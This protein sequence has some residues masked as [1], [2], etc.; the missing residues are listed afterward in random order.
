MKFILYA[1]LFLGF[2][3]DCFAQQKQVQGLVL[4]QESKLRLAKV[5][6]QNLRSGDALYNTTKGEFST[7]ASKGDTLVARLNGYKQD[8]II[9]NG[10][11]AVY[12][13]LKSI[14][15]RLRDVQ[16]Q[17]KRMTPK[18]RYE[19]S[20][21]DNRY[22][23]LRGSTDDIINLSNNGA[24]L[25]IDAIY[26]LFS[27]QGKN[28]RY[29]QKILKNDYRQQLIDY[30]FSPR[31]VT[32]V[33]NINGAEREDFMLQY[34]PTYQFVMDSNDYTFN[35]FIKNAY[36]SYRINPGALRLP[37]LPSLNPQK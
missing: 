13:Q 8:T 5:Y 12:F 11:A 32:Q 27:R 30:R 23:I 22:A 18:E 20:L 14:G 28:A 7:F 19:E 4:D 16:I 31:L 17:Q 34:R 2:V 15:I 24:G 10:Q 1:F 26:N 21:K 36:K 35:L 3:A 9:Y 29:L 37:D 25:G 6:I 33:L